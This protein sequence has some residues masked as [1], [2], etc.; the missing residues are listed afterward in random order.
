V[1]EKD[2]GVVLKTARSG[3]TSLLVTFLSRHRG[4]IRLMAKGVLSQKHPSRGLLET[5]NHVEIVYYYKENRSLYY[6]KEASS[7]LP[8][9]TE[10]YS[11]PHLAVHLAAMELLDQV[12]YP[13]SADEA[14]VAL[15]VEYGG[16]VADAKDPL[17]LFLAFELR[18]LAVLGAFPDL[19]G[20]AICQRAA[21][22]GTYS[23]RDGASFCREHGQEAPPAV[24][25]S[26]ALSAEAI[27]LVHRCASERLKVLAGKGVAKQTR[28]DLGKIV[29]W[30]Y[31]YHVQGY[32]LPKS[33]SLI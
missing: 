20:C 1:L 10:R 26:Q 29:H 3:E 12:C 24:P 16:V 18:L 30:T 15:A 31:T 22:S 25:G 9:F 14:I 13:G 7:L 8:S 23:A 27:A 32:N 4:K 19:T 17:F 6:L 2:E 33:L 11:L 21:G 5:G 28:K